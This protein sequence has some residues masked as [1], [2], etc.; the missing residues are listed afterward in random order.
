MLGGTKWEADELPTEEE[1]TVY[2]AAAPCFRVYHDG[3]EVEMRA[4]LAEL[5]AA[6]T[7]RKAIKEWLRARGCEARTP[8]EAV[9]ALFDM[10]QA[11]RAG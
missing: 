5:E 3:N 10:L 6:V 7:K 4:R 8:D 11:A 1:V 2:E 9:F